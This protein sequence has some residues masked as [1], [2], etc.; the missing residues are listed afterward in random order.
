MTAIGDLIGNES[1]FPVLAERDY[2]NHA[3]ISPTPRPTADAIREYADHFSRHSAVGYDF[4]GHVEGFRN[5]AASVINADADE[6][7]ITHHTSEG[8]GQVAFGL[9]WQPGDRVVTTAAEYP[10]N[11]YPWMAVAERFGVELV[12]VPEETDDAGQVRVRHDALLEACDHPRTKLLAVS[13]VQWGS[14]QRMDVA[15]LGAFCRD[16]GILFS[17]DA[18]QSF[19]V[20]P[21]DVKAMHI[22]FLQAGAHKWMLGAL[23]AGVLFVRRELWDALTPTSM[24][25]HSVVNPM[26]W[27]EIDFTL[28]ND[29]K[30]FEPGSPPLVSCAATRAGLT[31]LHGVGIENVARRVASFCD[32][33][34]DAL[35]AAGYRVVTPIGD[36]QS[37]D[38]RGAAV[39]F[40][41]KDGEPKVVYERMAKDHNTELASRCGRVRFS[42]HFYNTDKQVDRLVERLSS[43]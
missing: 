17:V 24:G 16:K 26:Q 23:G 30:R 31:L 40:V 6:V 43:L 42:P 15:R 7:A 10:S 8:I 27:E 36:S 21:V 19:G 12:V 9:D 38:L 18:I 37:D 32:R 25:W 28:Q 33:F 34:A 22:D 4:A 14:G 39:C 41:P 11:L 1:V 5:A 13:H 29:A 2:F 20:M 35:P 3:G